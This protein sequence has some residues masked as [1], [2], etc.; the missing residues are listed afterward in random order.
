M[1]FKIGDK[2]LV[3]DSIVKGSVAKLL[4]NKVFVLDEDGFE[5]PYT[6]NQLILVNVEQSKLS[7]YT[8]I[9]I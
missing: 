1:K 2:V 3:K 9:N 6:E 5:L 7:M 4:N 8:D